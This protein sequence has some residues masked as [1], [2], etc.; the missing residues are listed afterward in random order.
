[1]AQH[2]QNACDLLRYTLA[3]RTE[4]EKGKTSRP[5]T[6]TKRP[7]SQKKVLVFGLSVQ[8]GGV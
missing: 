7:M 1:M 6:P 8:Q 4:K 5:K 2:T 3:Q